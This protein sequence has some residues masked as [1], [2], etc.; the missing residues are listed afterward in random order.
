GYDAKTRNPLR[1]LHGVP[2]YFGEQDHPLHRDSL[3]RDFVAGAFV[4]GDLRKFVFR[5][6][7]LA[8][9]PGMGPLVA[10]NVVLP[11]PRLENRAPVFPRSRRLLPDRPLASARGADRPPGDRMGR[12]V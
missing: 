10:R 11:L 4:E 9:G 3:D 7:A 6:V 12:A 5:V 2:P 1:G 8:P